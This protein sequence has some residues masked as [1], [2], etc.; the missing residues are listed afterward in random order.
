MTD[1]GKLSASCL[2]FYY[3]VVKTQPV[4]SSRKTRCLVAQPLGLAGTADLAIRVL[5]KV[6]AGD[7]WKIL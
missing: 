3:K 1:E 4:E 2:D 6:T 7:F 5:V